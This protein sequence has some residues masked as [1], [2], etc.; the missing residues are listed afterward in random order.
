MFQSVPKNFIKFRLS[1]EKVGKS[2]EKLGN[3]F[4]VLGRNIIF[5]A[6]LIHDLWQQLDSGYPQKPTN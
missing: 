1:R 2:R 5:V 4:A 3:F 6:T